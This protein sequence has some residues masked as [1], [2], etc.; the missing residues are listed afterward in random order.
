ML[1]KHKFIIKKLYNDR[2]V[3]I[4]MPGNAMIH[5]PAQGLVV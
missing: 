4:K 5:L 3:N 1:S 2:I